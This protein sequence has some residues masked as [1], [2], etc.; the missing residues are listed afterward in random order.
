MS[1]DSW[2]HWQANI[3]IIIRTE[4]SDL[5]PYI[6][7]DEIDWDAWKPLY[8]QGYSPRIAVEQAISGSFDRT[9]AANE[10]QLVNA[11]HFASP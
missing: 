10:K 4:Y 1:I 2:Q 3:V 9:L 8:E 6:R 5:F 11:A 7:Q